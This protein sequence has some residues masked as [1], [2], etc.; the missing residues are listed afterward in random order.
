[1]QLSENLNIIQKQITKSGEKTSQAFSQA[2]LQIAVT[3]H[4]TV[5][6]HLISQLRED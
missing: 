1:M 4:M 3:Q 6:E 5:I 2:T